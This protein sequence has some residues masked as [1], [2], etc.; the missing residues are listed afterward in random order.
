M[1]YIL[2][3][4]VDDSLDFHHFYSRKVTLAYSAEA[5]IY[6]PG[7]FG[8]M[9]ELFEILTL[10]QTRKI[11]NVPI[12]LYGSEFW[13]PLEDYFKSVFLKKGEETISQEDLALYTITDSDEEILEIIKNADVRTDISNT[14]HLGQK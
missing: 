9:D 4:Y 5:Y 6:C 8:T 3:E 2:H 13:R 14:H 11:P 12:I 7:G 10:K 1:L